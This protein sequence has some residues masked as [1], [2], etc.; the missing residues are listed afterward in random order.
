MIET[1]KEASVGSVRCV[2]G[3]EL[4]TRNGTTLAIRYNSPNR[5]LAEVDRR[6][7]YR[8]G[9]YRF[10][11]SKWYYINDTLYHSQ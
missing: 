8:Y 6:P 2:E 9:M 4:S 11:C 5:D 7:S 1:E 10:K 3:T